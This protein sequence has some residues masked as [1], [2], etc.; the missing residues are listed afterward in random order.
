[1]IWIQYLAL[2]NLLM[3]FGSN[4]SLGH[5]FNKQAVQQYIDQHAIE[6]VK[7]KLFK[8]N[9][10]VVNYFLSRDS[11]REKLS[12]TNKS[13]SIEHLIQFLQI[14]FCPPDVKEK[15]REKRLKDAEIM[16]K[17]L[18][19]KLCN[20]SQSRISLKTLEKIAWHKI[21]K[22][23]NKKLMC[24]ESE[25]IK[26]ESAS[27]KIYDLD[28]LRKKTNSFLKSESEKLKNSIK[29][30]KEW[31]LFQLLQEKEKKEFEKMR[32][33][34]IQRKIKEKKALKKQ[35]LQYAKSNTSLI[36]KKKPLY[37][38]LEKNTNKNVIMPELKR[39]KEELRKKSMYFMPMKLKNVTEHMHWFRS[40]KEKFYSKNLSQNPNKS[41]QTL[42]VKPC[43]FFS[44]LIDEEKISH[45][46]RIK[47]VLRKV[48]LIENNAKISTITKEKYI[49]CLEKSPL[50]FSDI[51]NHKKKIAAKGVPTKL[52]SLTC[53]QNS[54][55][56]SP[57]QSYE[58]RNNIVNYKK[59]RSLDGSFFESILEQSFA[60]GSTTSQNFKKIQEDYQNLES[61]ARKN[62]YSYTLYQHLLGKTKKKTVLT[63]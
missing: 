39:R 44:K 20:I 28:K 42:S 24:L 8:S 61:L 35:E 56:F 21:T 30:V 62:Q 54:W 38:N 50:D 32:K 13:A 11:Y 46:A 49:S 48:N 4:S 33:L 17:D 47:N 7:F 3:L 43:I 19:D 52:K 22:E 58:N 6:L 12:L 18:Q 1:M 10:K 29:E 63:I 25:K 15:F 41:F 2:F 53:F 51:I 36:I 57:E 55:G 23:K 5:Y 16:K 60:S 31:E 40:V 34:E 45:E 27:S 26:T 14:Q 37:T 59:E 9:F